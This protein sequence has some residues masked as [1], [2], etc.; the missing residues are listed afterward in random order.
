MRDR[1]LERPVE[2]LTHWD[3]ATL[4]EA[5]LLTGRFDDARDWYGR[6]AGKAAGVHQD[7]AVMRRQA[8]LDLEALGQPRD[9]LDAVLPFPEAD[10][11]VTSVGGVWNERFV[12]LRANARVE[13]VP[14]LL[15]SPPPSAELPRAFSEA[16]REVQRR[17]LAYSRRLD[18]TP[19]VLAVWDGKK[20]DG[21]GGTADAVG[22]WQDEGYDVDVNDITQ[23]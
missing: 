11:L 20:G 2:T 19:T 4:G 1:L 5:F 10:F 18:E 8:R 23:V 16:N 14:P 6:G 3:L 9:R 7:I 21:P 22:L 17:A 15:P 13:F 12:K